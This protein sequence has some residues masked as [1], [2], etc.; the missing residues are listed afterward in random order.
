VLS[1]ENYK[2][3]LKTDLKNWEQVVK[4]EPGYPDGWAKLAIIWLS[5]GRRDLSLLAIKEARNLAFFRDDLKDLE[6]KIANF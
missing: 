4:Q 5:L 2:R 1:T 3:K 6:E